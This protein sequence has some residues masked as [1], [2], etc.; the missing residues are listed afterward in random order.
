MTQAIGI[1]ELTSIARGM[2]LGDVMLKSANVQLLLCRTLCPG[3]FLLMLGGDVGAVQQAIAAGT[4][5]AGEMLV[6]SLVLANIHPSV[7]PAISGL[8]VVEQRQAAGIVETWSVAAC[9]SAADRAVK[10]ANV[11]LVR[12]HMAFGI[13]GKCY[14][15]VAGDIADVDN[16]VTVASDSAGEKGLLVYRAVLGA[17]ERQLQANQRPQGVA[18]Q[19]KAGDPRRLQGAE[20]LLGHRRHAVVGGQRAGVFPGPVMVITHQLILCLQRRA[21]RQPVAA[22][23]AQTG[24]EDHHRRAG[25]W[26]WSNI[27][28]H[29]VGVPIWATLAISTSASGFTSPH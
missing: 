20:Q 19:R 21:L 10:A 14:M 6:D 18:H 2:E 1:L 5:R 16:A 27:E 17:I 25:P 13:G 11:T 9:I 26:G 29:H 7:L 4:A 8:N 24:A 22:A 3:K 28:P 12:V 15:V 23:A